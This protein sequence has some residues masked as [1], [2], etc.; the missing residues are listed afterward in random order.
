MPT[1][2][3]IMLNKL[4]ILS[5]LGAERAF[6]STVGFEELSPIQIPPAIGELGDLSKYPYVGSFDAFRQLS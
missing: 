1:P 3:F 2:L 5:E 4:S 6:I